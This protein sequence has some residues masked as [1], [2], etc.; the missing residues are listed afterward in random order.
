MGPCKLVLYSQKRVDAHFNCAVE[1]T[2]RWNI[3]TSFADQAMDSYTARFPR[4][5]VRS[6]RFLVQ[7]RLLYIPP[8]VGY[9]N[10][11]QY[12]FVSRLIERGERSE[13]I[14]C[15]TFRSRGATWRPM[16]YLIKWRAHS[17]TEL[18]M[19]A[20]ADQRVPITLDLC[21]VERCKDHF[22]IIQEDRTFTLDNIKITP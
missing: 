11:V 19:V 10:T 18:I 16:V 3:R 13:T 1:I 8:P 22:H 12:L 20:S 15:K 9:F 4:P 2:L 21:Y 5:L 6:G 7:R 14:F 17:P